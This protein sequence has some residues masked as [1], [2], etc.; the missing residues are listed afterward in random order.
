MKPK[1]R[2]I[3]LSPRMWL[4][5]GLF[6]FGAATV[7]TYHQDQLAANV[8][9]AEKVG[10]PSQVMIQN[11]IPERHTNVLDEVDLLVEA[12]FGE[13]ESVNLGT[14]DAPH[15]VD[16]V[17]IYSVSNEAFPLAMSVLRG[18]DLEQHRPVSRA[19]AGKVA[20]R[21]SR[22]KTMEQ[23]PLG[24][25]L[26]D[27]TTQGSMEIDTAHGL[28]KNG[29]LLSI[30]GALLRGDTLFARIST[31]ME[32][33]GV[34]S[35]PDMLMV[36]PYQNR[37]MV[38]ADG[39]EYNWLRSS[40][41]WLGFLFAAFSLMSFSSDQSIALIRRFKRKPVQPVQ[42]VVA[43]GAFPAVGF[44]QPIKTQSELRVEEEA[45][46]AE[47]AGPTGRVISRIMG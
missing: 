8:V 29:P 14:P 19:D 18:G 22:L 25:A 44:F 6:C 33:R 11:F 37:N 21:V 23:Q 2:N 36:T 9:L 41:I 17:P 31:A 34:A 10:F 27:S 12:G 40:L 32:A 45:R 46:A 16:V 42:D 35:F 24:Y 3:A 39:S 13:A 20:K 43:V 15:N 1:L 5:A 38:V 26:F 7:V 28:G 30:T 47:A 4:S